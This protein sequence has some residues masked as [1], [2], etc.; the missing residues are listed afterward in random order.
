[1]KKKIIFFDGDGTI[2]HPK[3]KRHKHPSW[4]Y[5]LPITEDEKTLRLKMT[6]YSLTTL[7]SLKKSGIITIMLSTHPH[8]PKEANIILKKKLVHFNLKD[9]FD[10]AYATTVAKNSKGKFI[11]K[12][13]KRRNIPKN[14]ALM[15]GDSYHWDYKSAK[16]IG[17]D[18]LLIETEHMKRNPESKRRKKTIKKL[19]DLLKHI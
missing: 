10:E 1:M 17:V 4:I 2:W 3:T 16:D 12:I 15:I 14:K 7:K 9:V 18:A 6:P 8:P 11:E 13:L 19:S 5:R